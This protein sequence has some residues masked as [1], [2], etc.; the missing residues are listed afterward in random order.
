ME[1][2][3]RWNRKEGE[4][5]GNEQGNWKVRMELEISERKKGQNKNVKDLKVKCKRA[6]EKEDPENAEKEWRD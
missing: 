3:E 4:I 2:G 6:M 1:K 5:E